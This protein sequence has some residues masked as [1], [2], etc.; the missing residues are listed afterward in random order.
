[1]KT[2]AVIIS[3]ILFIIVS[4]FYLAWVGEQLEARLYFPE[5]FWPF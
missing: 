5:F 4:V 2:S 3:L 1:M